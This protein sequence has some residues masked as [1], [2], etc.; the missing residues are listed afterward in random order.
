MWA[1]DG[2]HG[3][4]DGCLAEPSAESGLP[5]PS[6]WSSDPGASTQAWA[7]DPVRAP[8][9]RSTSCRRSATRSRAQHPGRTPCGRTCE[10]SGPGEGRVAMSRWQRTREESKV[11]HAASIGR[12]LGRGP[13]SRAPA[14]S[15]RQDDDPRGPCDG[16][17]GAKDGIR[18]EA[19]VVVAHVGVTQQRCER[20]PRSM[21]HRRG[22]SMYALESVM[23]CRPEPDSPIRPPATSDVAS[24]MALPLCQLANSPPRTRIPEK[25]GVKQKSYIRPGGQ[26]E[27]GRGRQP[28]PFVSWVKSSRCTEAVEATEASDDGA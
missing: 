8:R 28:D 27:A 15:P 1:T 5:N 26:P 7:A 16:S 4:S 13:P 22:S 24:E 6:T 20:A 11:P 12:V 14:R 18:D 19:L 10:E 2:A 3:A 21:V 9:G 23:L 25:K 17:L